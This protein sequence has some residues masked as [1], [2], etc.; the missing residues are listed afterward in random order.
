MEFELPRSKLVSDFND[1]HR[2]GQTP[3]SAKPETMR[4]LVRVASK[5]K[6]S[7]TKEKLRLPCCVWR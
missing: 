1:P 5:A 7:R 3:H 4:Y 6:T 2:K